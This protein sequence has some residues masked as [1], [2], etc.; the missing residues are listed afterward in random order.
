M[1]LN[2]LQS[3]VL[4][5]V[6]GCVLFQLSGCRQGSELQETDLQRTA[7]GRCAAAYFAAFNSD[8]DEM[9]RGF[10]EE[11]RSPDF[12]QRHPVEQRLA[13]HNH[14]RDIFGTLTPIRVTL[15]LDLQATLLVDPSK[16]GDVLVV[17]F[18]LEEAPPHKLSYITFSGI[19]RDNVP[20]EYV[21]Y[22]ATRAAP[23]GD[24]LRE[25]TVGSVADA[26]RDVYVY[27][28]LGRRMADTLLYHR[29]QGVYRDL[30]K[31]GALADRLTDD[32]VSVSGDV[33]VW[34]EAQNPMV[35]VSSDPVN[36]DVGELRRDNFDF[37]EA[38]VLSGNIG[39]IKFDMIHDDED[40]QEIIATAMAEVAA[41]DALIVDLRDNIGGEWGT[42]GLL[43]GYVLPGGT[44]VSRVFD[45]EGAV[46]EER[47]VPS[48]IPGKPFGAEVPVYVLTS[49]RTGSAAEALA[50]TLKHMGRATVVGEVTRGAA[51]PS[52][53]IVVNDYFRASVPFLRSENVNTG[54]DWE[55]V[56]VIPD[57]EVP[58]EDAKETA[59]NDAL[60]RIR[61][62]H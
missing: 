46:V 33:H 31:A 34:V 10:V 19:D 53:E 47:A 60:R 35:Q 20:D 27:P 6:V 58:A 59:V 12:L 42:A 17:R 14:L 1:R 23:V 7:A 22:V 4:W 28:E 61:S 40:A 5:V 39:Y 44:I 51:H 3:Q 21:D 56:G 62:E 55:R 30:T 38:R 8:G 25:G 45:R 41:C 48:G 18:Q 13:N 37:K 16:I 2:P 50:Y 32:A 11:Y 36:R 57:I 15:S 43:L 24:E 52:K 29:A 9:L 54:T 49:E 26:L